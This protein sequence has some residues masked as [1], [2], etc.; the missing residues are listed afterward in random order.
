MVIVEYKGGILRI[1]ENHATEDEDEDE[2]E[3]EEKKCRQ[4]IS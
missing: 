3:D 1:W 2:D 4:Q